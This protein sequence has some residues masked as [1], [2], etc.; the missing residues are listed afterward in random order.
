MEICSSC[1]SSLISLMAVNLSLKGTSL[2]PSSWVAGSQAKAKGWP[3]PYEMIITPS[4][5]S[6]PISRLSPRESCWQSAHKMT[7][8]VHRLNMRPQMAPYFLFRA[9]LWTRAYL[10]REQGSIWD[11]QLTKWMHNWGP[12]DNLHLYSIQHQSCFFMDY[13]NLYCF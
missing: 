4:S 9:L 7:D 6:G 11:T 8:S 2:H 3:L 1:V 10:Y 5:P 12:Q 13:I